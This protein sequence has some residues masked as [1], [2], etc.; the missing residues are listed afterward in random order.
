MVLNNHPHLVHCCKYG[1]E[2]DLKMIHVLYEP[3]AFPCWR[4]AYAA[5]TFERWRHQSR[6]D[7]LFPAVEINEIN[8]R[9]YDNALGQMSR[10]VLF[11]TSDFVGRDVPILSTAELISRKD[12]GE[13]LTHVS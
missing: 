7:P 10:S 13:D 4:N 5:H 6:N 8:V 11:G 1:I 12:R 2:A 3:H 9:D